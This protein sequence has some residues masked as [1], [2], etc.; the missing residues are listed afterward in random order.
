MEVV[1]CVK[2][3]EIWIQDED[4]FLMSILIYPS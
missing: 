4:Y 3:Y 1:D 2:L